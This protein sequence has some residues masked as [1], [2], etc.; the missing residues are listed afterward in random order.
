MSTRLHGRSTAG[1]GVGSRTGAGRARLRFDGWITGIG[2]SSGVRAVVGHWA[3][4]P[5]GP[6]SDVMIERPDGHRILLAPTRE[7]A[8]F[9]AGTYA[10]DE[11]RVVPVGV[12]V[13]GRAWTVRAS[14]LRLHYVSG[15]RGL[16]GLLL[17]AVPGS[18][19][20]RPA[21]AAAVALP[22]RALLRV[23]TRGAA[24][25]GRYEWYGARDLRPVL[26]AA[27]VYEG[28]DLGVLTS[29]LPPV[30]FGFSSTPW[31][32][33]VVRVTVTVS[34]ERGSGAEVRP[35]GGGSRRRS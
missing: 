3:R 35:D 27:A 25:R 30:R 17:R 32:P 34:L 14:T 10:F 7:T 23:S 5:F 31:K 13:V 24:G 9:I 29:V 33:C 18:L 2:T 15:R 11:V 26:S 8:D 6:F 16:A 28:R 21:W 22:A 20:A 4:S 12:E 19:A 1:S